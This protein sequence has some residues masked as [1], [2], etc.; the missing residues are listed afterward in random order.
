MFKR[1]FDSTTKE[2]KVATK[3]ADQI[4]ALEDKYKKYSDEELQAMTPYFRKEIADGKTLDDILVDA[5]A[6]SREACRRVL[7]LHPFKVQLEGAYVL[8]GGNVA[9][10]R[11]GE[12]KT[13]TAV[14][15]SYL[16]ALGGRGVHIITV[17]EYLCRIQSEEMGRVFN[18]LG[19]TVGLNLRDLS[20]DEKRE[21][22]N[23]DI[24][25]STNAEVGFDYLRDH[26]VLYKEQMVQ[27]PLN[28][29][30]IDEAD[31]ILI[32][33]ARTPLIISGGAK[34]T[35]A[36]YKQADMAVKM[37]S[38]DDYDIDLKD[39]TVQLTDSGISSIE[40]FFKI[41]NLYDVKYVDLLHR[42][43]NALRAN[44]IMANEVDYVVK[45]GAVI[46]VDSFTGRLMQ[47][48]QFSEGLHQALE[49][50][51]GVKVNSETVTVATIT[52]QNFFRMYNKLSG[53][54]GT[55]K[56]E[57]EEFQN[58]YNMY[59]VEVPT[60][61]PIIRID[62]PDYL[63]A[64]MKDK[65]AAIT[66]EIV[67]RH[68]TGQPILIGTVAIETSEYLSRLLKKAG[69][70]HNVL[71]AKQHERE[72][73]IVAH[74]GEKN[75]VTI[76]TNMAGRGTDIKL[77]EGVAELGG[78]AVIGTERHEA[79]RIDNQLRGR[80]GRQG[81]P[82]FSRFYLSAEDNLLIRFGGDRFKDLINRA[83]DGSG[84]PIESKMITKSVEQAQKRI[85]GNNFDLRKSI[86]EYDE[87]IRMQ[88]EVIYKE[89]EEILT[90]DSI[91]NLVMR[92]VDNFV[93]DLLYKYSD[94]KG[95]INYD[96]LLNELNKEVFFM[97]KFS[98]SDLESKDKA[99]I[100]KLISD[101]I[102]T[103]IY[104]KQ[105][106]FPPNIFNEFLKVITLRVVDTHWVRHIDTMDG[107]RQS[108]R[109][110]AYGQVNPLNE[111][112]DQG[113]ALFNDMTMNINKDV[114]RYVLRAQIKT[115]QEREEVA[116]PTKESSGKEEKR[117]PIVKKKK[118][119]RNDPCPCGSGKKYKNCC[120]R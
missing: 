113:L 114:T 74:A 43:N 9:E 13:L 42:I 96:S 7:G 108:V 4:M 104:E 92:M 41:D 106:K 39:K 45:D 16:N 37:L 58:I 11:T 82:G 28:F 30:I 5:Y 2:L 10:M 19:L 29:A 98:L 26:M 67:K 73:E 76:A 68:K 102:K 85:E 75:A 65:Y 81:D 44:Y 83:S 15:P 100:S 23:C 17:N 66:K 12:G 53:M 110:Q 101:V 107:L 119:G 14:M 59:V 25:Y 90:E 80:S 31:S 111:F 84:N 6:V 88:R 97:D 120:G 51:E 38:E 86:L 18:F 94:E 1:L 60:N 87:V 47:G 46:I 62:A 69:V 36:M 78:L 22:Y 21:Q 109:L 105:K 63:Y 72:A 27:R 71:N 32:D 95:H 54:T 34:T 55:A 48:R 117:Q 64:T 56:T 112:K 91:L 49:A 115:N 3:V 116:K 89:R 33:E 20:K 118:I 70:P 40:R 24:M 77:G 103:S 93:E 61:K 52:Y 8:H 50:K 57:E 79:R 99:E 35:Q